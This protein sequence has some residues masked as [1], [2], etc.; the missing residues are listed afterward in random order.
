MPT[1]ANLSR[2]FLLKPDP[3]DPPQPC[4]N[5]ISSASSTPSSSNAHSTGRGNVKQEAAS[6]KSHSERAK[7]DT[8]TGASAPRVVMRRWASDQAVAH[9]RQLLSQAS[10]TAA[11]CGGEER[12]KEGRGVDAQEG[13]QGGPQ[14][15]GAALNGRSG[16]ESS[17]VTR[18]VTASPAA[19]AL[20]G[21]SG[22]ASRWLA[23]EKE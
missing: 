2:S 4:T 1:I 6:G 16:D 5:A 21:G 3:P 20:G 19:G 14:P 11:G 18:P 7:R 13:Q 15:P 8:A 9:R 10:L 17:P 12:H 23:E 22:Y